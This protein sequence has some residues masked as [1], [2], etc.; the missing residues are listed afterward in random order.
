MKRIEFFRLVILCTV[1]TLKYRVC[2]I[3]FYHAMVALFGLLVVVAA[4]FVRIGLRRRTE[5]GRGASGGVT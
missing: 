5:V 3:E 1:R 4:V 2:T